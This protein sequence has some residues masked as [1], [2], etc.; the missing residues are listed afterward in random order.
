MDVAYWALDLKAPRSI[1]VNGGKFFLD[2]A[3]ETPDSVEA[4]LEYPELTLLFTMHPKPLPGF[5][6]MGGIGCVFQG[7]EATLV[8]N[9]EKH[10][11]YVDGKL[12]EDFPVPTLHIPD[13]HGHL[14][15]FLDAVKDRDTETTCNISY[16]YRLTKAGLLV[17]I[18]YRTGDRIYW[19]DETETIIGNEGANQ[20]LGR[21]FRKPWS[22]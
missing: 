18:A 19:N 17:N 20:L 13:S 12:A 7:T 14:R 8:T 16:G 11:V 15:E 2:D 22:I 21:V 5:E 1:S 10:E 9:Y 4:M 3:T 6:H